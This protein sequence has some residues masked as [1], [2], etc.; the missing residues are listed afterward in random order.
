MLANRAILSYSLGKFEFGI[1]TKR[2]YQDIYVS[3]LHEMEQV[4]LYK[5][6]VSI[7]TDPNAWYNSQSV[8]Q[9]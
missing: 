1:E 2:I 8:L 9:D 6:C 3:V 7:F 5:A 4:K